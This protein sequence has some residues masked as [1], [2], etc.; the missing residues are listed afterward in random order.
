MGSL[1]NVATLC[2]PLLRCQAIVSRQDVQDFQDFKP[3]N[4]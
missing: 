3:A 4:D 2:R 1:K